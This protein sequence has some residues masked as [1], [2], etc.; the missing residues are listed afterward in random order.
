MCPPSSQQDIR[1][2]DGLGVRVGLV[3]EVGDGVKDGVGDGVSEGRIVSIGGSEIVP[4]ISLSNVG[5]VWEATCTPEH[6]LPTIPR[7]TK[8]RI[9]QDCFNDSPR[10]IFIPNSG[11]K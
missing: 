9:N 2:G 7:A 1:V 3:V 8:T 5:L 6:A 4:K 10:V 11:K